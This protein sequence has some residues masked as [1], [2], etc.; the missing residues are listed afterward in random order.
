MTLES[1]LL[2]IVAAAALTATP[3]PNVAL[4][5]GTSLRYGLRPG[6]TVMSGVNAGLVIQLL[7]VVAGLTWVMEFFSQWFDVIRYAGAAYLVVLA[8]G[9]LFGQSKAN[10]GT[11]ERPGISGRRA[12]MN[13]LAVA[14]SNPKTLLFHAAFLPL[15]LSGGAGQTAEIWLLAATFA[16][17][18]AIGD[19]LF[20]V[21][22]ALSA[23]AVSA[24]YAQITNKVSAGILLGGAAVLLA[25]R[26]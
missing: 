18:A 2:F 14:L 15:F 20:A 6:L 16:V 3:G 11:A 17:V 25:M 1:Y 9:Q 4:I 23:S 12:F 22:A 10:R 26:R 21:I 5:V 7:A 8:L 13:G 19:A 24:R